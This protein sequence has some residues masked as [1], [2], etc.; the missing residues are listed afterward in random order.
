MPI[1]LQRAIETRISGD[2]EGWIYIEQVD[3]EL[4]SDCVCLTVDQF[5]Q[6]VLHADQIRR[7]AVEPNELL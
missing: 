2:G 5:N 3:P 4:N 1:T 7:E 6:L